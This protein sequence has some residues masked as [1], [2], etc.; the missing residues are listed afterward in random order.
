MF[1]W[2]LAALVLGLAVV[3]GFVLDAQSRTAVKYPELAEL[4]ETIYAPGRIEG[5][6]RPVELRCQL[7]GRIAAVHVRE[8]QWV[9][10][11]QVL[12][13]LDAQQ[14]CCEVAQA[15]AE[16]AQAQAQLERLVAGARPEERRQS[17][18]RYRA[19]LAELEQAELA[20]KR[21]RE[22]RQSHAV[23][24]QEADERRTAVA[25]L[26]AEVEAAKAAAE[27]LE[28]PPRPDELR[29]HQ[30]RVAAAQARLDLAKVLLQRC[31]LKAPIAAQVLK[32]DA[33]PGELTGP[34]APRPVIILADTRR[35]RVR[36]F[37][38][39]FDAPRLANGMMAQITADG[40]PGQTFTGR[41][42][43]LSPAMSPKEL[44]SDHPAERYDTKNREIWIDLD[45]NPQSTG[46]VVGLRVEVTIARNQSYPLSTDPVQP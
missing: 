42:A 20:W 19:K 46:L 26:T 34:D 16:L 15:E 5:A 33:E 8:G 12:L 9:E 23:S 37:V 24:P 17:A 3:L 11:D 7:A 31:Q 43:S 29:L 30:A 40:L 41:V 21:I 14:Y 25:A 22:L 36:A 35:L 44:W 28:A 2:T 39:E 1:R 18:A 45:P 13:E 38:E 4:P 32:V 6:T 27:L 10:K